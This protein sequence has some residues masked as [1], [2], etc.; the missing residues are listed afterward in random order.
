[1]ALHSAGAESVTLHGDGTTS[2]RSVG[3]APV[4]LG[5]STD[6]VTLK[7]YAYGVSGASEVHVQIAGEEVPLLYAGASG[8][9][10]GLDEVMVRVPQSLAGRGATDVTLTADGQAA[11]PV[12]IRIQ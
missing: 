8:Y 4:D 5:I 10:P 7:F 11:N 3:A 6:A 12:H 2:V 1:V 9:F